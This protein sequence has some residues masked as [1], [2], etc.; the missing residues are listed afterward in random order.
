MHQ[1]REE[2]YDLYDECLPSAHALA[3]VGRTCLLL[4]LSQMERLFPTVRRSIIDQLSDMMHPKESSRT[5][6]NF[7]SRTEYDF[8]SYNVAPVILAKNME[9]IYWTCGGVVNMVKNKI[10]YWNYC[11]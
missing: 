2:C 3:E 11:P 1:S 10:C 8:M 9:T 5:S 6:D 7:V 4:R